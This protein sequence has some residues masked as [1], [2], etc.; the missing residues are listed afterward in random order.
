MGS[1]QQGLTKRLKSTTMSIYNIKHL[2]DF[3]KKISSNLKQMLISRSLEVTLN[4]LRKYKGQQDENGLHFGNKFF[5]VYVT[6][7]AKKLNQTQL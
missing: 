5:I 1:I 6:S 2:S 3:N 4:E 7:D